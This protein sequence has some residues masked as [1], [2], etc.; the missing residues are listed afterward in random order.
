[1]SRGRGRKKEIWRPFKAWEQGE[2]GKGTTLL[3]LLW[4]NFW[5]TLYVQPKKR[6]GGFNESWRI[7]LEKGEKAHRQK[8]DRH[9]RGRKGTSRVVAT[10]VLGPLKKGGKKKKCV[11]SKIL[12]REFTSISTKRGVSR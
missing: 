1:V 7:G 10:L 4:G 2:K 6:G 3:W 12:G 11:T 5:E 8:T 9:C